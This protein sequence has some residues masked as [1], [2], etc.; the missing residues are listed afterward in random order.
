MSASTLTEASSFSLLA[1]SEL[2]DKSFHEIFESIFEFVLHEKRTYYDKKKSQ[3]TINAAATRLSKCAAAVRM[4]TGRGVAK[5]GRKTMKAIIEHI[6]QVLCAHD[7]FVPPLLQDYVKALTEVLSRPSHVELSARQDGSLWVYCVDFLLDIAS[8]ILPEEVEGESTLL[9]LSRASPAPGSGLPSTRRS[10]PSTQSQKRA[11]HVEGGPLKDVLE[12]LLYLVTGS[13]SPLLRRYEEIAAVILRVLSMKQLSLGSVQTLGFSILNA[14]LSATQADDLNHSNTLVRRLL[15]LMSYWWR[16][17]KVSQHEVIRALRIEISRSIVLTHL[18][19]EKLT[20][21]SPDETIYRDIEDLAENMWI[22]YSKRS[23]SY[24]LQLGDVTFS[25][26]NLP[27]YYPKLPLFGLRA[28]NVYGEGHWAVVENLAFLERIMILY[29]EKTSASALSVDQQPR[30]RRRAQQ[31]VS[32]IR[33]KLKAADVQL[34][35]TALQLVPFLLSMGGFGRDELLDLFGHVVSLAGDKSPITASW[36][37]VACARY[38]LLLPELTWQLTP[39]SCASSI[40]VREETDTWRKLWHLATRSIGLPGTSR[41]A[42]VALHAMI[43]VDVLPYHSVS[44]DI[45]GIVTSADV[46]GPGILCDSSIAFMLN[47]LRIRNS[48]V[49]SASHSTCNHV[50]RWVF[51]RWNP[52]KL[53]RFL[54]KRV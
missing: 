36:A 35:R 37:L 42:C 39:N 51:L 54:K 11:A 38:D 26:S 13:N 14:I 5:L 30:K 19:M 6:T 40:Q 34:Q 43:G 16:S 41:A 27:S 24:R 48:R 44:E 46:N 47:I 4:A 50:I 12:G 28:H 9:V 53:K 45:S 29:R 23:E 31:E 18:H 25:P 52:S 49:P 17:E 1:S 32:R 15:P 2:G 22:E 10:T 20:L 33:L 21:G 3:A 7:D 8:H